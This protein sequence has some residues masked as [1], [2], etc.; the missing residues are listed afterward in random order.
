MTNIWNKIFRRDLYE[1]IPADDL[2][3][4]QRFVLFRI[5]SISAFI[6]AIAVSVQEQLTFENPG[7]LPALLVLLA[8][9]IITNYFLVNNIYKLKLAYWILLVSGF[10]LLHAQ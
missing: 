4:R 5:F 3:S 2:M 6:A 8:V 9:T 10:L 1:Q 7:F